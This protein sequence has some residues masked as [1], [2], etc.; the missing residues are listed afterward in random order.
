MT[1]KASHHHHRPSIRLWI[2]KELLLLQAFFFLSDGVPLLFFLLVLFTTELKLFSNDD[3]VMT[4]KRMKLLRTVQQQWGCRGWVGERIWYPLSDWH[5]QTFLSGR[6][7]VVQRVMGWDL[8]M[9][10][11]RR[12]I[13]RVLQRIDVE[14]HPDM[15]CA[16]LF[17]YLK[18]RFLRD[19]F[20]KVALRYFMTRQSAF[21]W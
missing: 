15:G 11:D 17:L 7:N 4:W 20:L 12:R 13:E 16:R 6:F 21:L 14:V 19:G 8:A 10:S 9:D 1:R 18:G 2:M 5:Q 3:D